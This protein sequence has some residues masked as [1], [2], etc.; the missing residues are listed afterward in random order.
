MSEFKSYIKSQCYL[1]KIKNPT[2]KK[3]TS[4]QVIPK[5]KYMPNWITN[6]KGNENWN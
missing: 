5:N 3:Q 1:L 4:I 2:A 6:E